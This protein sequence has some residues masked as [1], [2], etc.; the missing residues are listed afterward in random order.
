MT[1]SMKRIHKVTIK[2][3][4]DDSPDTSWMGEYGNRAE[5][6]YAIDREHSLDCPVNT[7]LAFELLPEE[8]RAECDCGGHGDKERNE[9]R[10]FNGPVENYKGES[11]ENIRKYVRQDYERMQSLQRGDF[12]FVGIRAEAEVSFAECKGSR[13]LQEITSGG[14]WVIESDSGKEH[15]AEIERDEL[16]ELREQLRGMGFSKRAIA[17]AFKQIERVS[18]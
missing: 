17:A 8:D 9:Y 7:G 10:Y 5:T 4:L 16:A 14:L 6:E 18:E 11:P 2:R 13:L 1:K 15:F 3:M 12:C